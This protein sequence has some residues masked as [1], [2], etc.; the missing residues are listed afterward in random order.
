MSPDFTYFASL[1]V[2]GAFSHSAAGIFLFC[3][4]ASIVVYIVFYLLLRQPMIALMPEMLASRLA[5]R[6][7]W[8]PKS[9][10]SLLVV[11]GSMLVGALTH[12]VWDAFT[13][14]NTFVVGNVDILR[15]RLGLVEGVTIPLYKLLQHVST[16]VGLAALAFSIVRWMRRTP[17][18]F[19]RSHRLSVAMRAW[20][21]AA[22]LIAG[23]AGSIAGAATRPARTLEHLVFNG[24]V[25]G[26]A[27]MALAMLMFCACWQMCALRRA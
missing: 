14:A 21:G 9:A 6:P 27:W 23:M 3:L 19:G 4:P 12:V 1:G 7:E 15:I 13:H 11:I 17:P 25:S 26:M 20:L 18:Q 22:F 24:V 8:V 2:R 16:L 5:P 10:S